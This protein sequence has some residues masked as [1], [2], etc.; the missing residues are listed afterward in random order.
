MET[1]DADG[2]MVNHQPKKRGEQVEELS[3]NKKRELTVAYLQEKVTRGGKYSVATFIRESPELTGH[4]HNTV[5]GWLRKTQH[6]LQDEV[7]F[8]QEVCD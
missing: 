1:A 8:E 4:K 5:D 7:N 6:Q 2:V 3:I